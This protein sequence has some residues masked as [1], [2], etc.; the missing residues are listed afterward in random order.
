MMSTVFRVSGDDI[1]EYDPYGTGF[2]DPEEYTALAASRPVPIEASRVT[3]FPVEEV[4]AGDPVDVALFPALQQERVGGGQRGFQEEPSE[5][6]NLVDPGRSIALFAA[7]LSAQCGVGIDAVLNSQTGTLTDEY[8]GFAMTVHGDI[9]RRI[10]YADVSLEMLMYEIPGEPNE[11]RNQFVKAI[12]YYKKFSAPGSAYLTGSYVRGG[13][14]ETR[15]FNFSHNKMKERVLG[16]AYWGMVNWFRNVIVADNP[17]LQRH[18]VVIAQAEAK[19]RLLGARPPR[20]R[21]RKIITLRPRVR[22]RF[23]EMTGEESEDLL[24]DEGEGEDEES[25]MSAVSPLKKKSTPV[26]V[27]MHIAAGRRGAS[28]DDDEQLD[29]LTEIIDRAR[30]AVQS[31]ELRM[32]K[33]LRQGYVASGG[34]VGYWG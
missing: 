10:P 25:F 8:I 20:P 26:D 3:Q 22:P 13:G 28:V 21:K 15:Q 9:A 29:R 12:A 34:S 4:A 24:D 18:R 31:I 7:M 5:D 27:P 14:Y 33:V 17:M 19:L 11:V 6:A 30:E 2:V 1:E 16:N 23:G 32:P